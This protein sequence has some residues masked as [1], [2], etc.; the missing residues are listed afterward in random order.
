MKSFRTFFSF[1]ISVAFFCQHMNN[2]GPF[3]FFCLFQCFFK[4][5]QVMTVNRSEILKSERFKKTNIRIT[6]NH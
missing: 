5:S 1:F 3:M 2:A 6:K 4:A